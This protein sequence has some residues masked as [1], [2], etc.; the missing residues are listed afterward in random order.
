MS[1][2]ATAPGLPARKLPNSIVPSIR[3]WGLIQVTTKA[4]AASLGRGMLTSTSRSRVG[5]SRSRPM[6]IHHDAA[7]HDQ[8]QAL[9][10]V[11]ALHQRADAEEAGQRQA[12]VEG[13]HDQGGEQGPPPGLGQGGVDDEQ[14][15]HP[16][17]GDIG[18]TDG[19]PWR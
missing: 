6:P 1:W 9:Q 4:L 12:D 18:Q 8:N 16:D 10:P 15:L 19:R 11:E 17:G 7:A 13:D 14:V 5:L 2:E 3:A